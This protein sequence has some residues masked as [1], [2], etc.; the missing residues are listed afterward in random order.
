MDKSILK[1]LTQTVLIENSTGTT[2]HGTVE[3]GPPELCKA[4]VML[5]I[6]AVRDDQNNEV[7][8]SGHIYLDGKVVVGIK[9]R[10]TLPNGSKPPILSV[11]PQFD[12]DGSVHHWTVYF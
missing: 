10:V 3:Y 4:L 2:K 12:L 1:L 6:K 8:S 5:E 9:S 7:V 11:K